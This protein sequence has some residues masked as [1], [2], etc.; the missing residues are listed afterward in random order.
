MPLRSTY[1]VLIA[2]LLNLALNA[3]SSRSKKGRSIQP[4]HSNTKLGD[5]TS[6]STGLKIGQNFQPTSPLSVNLPPGHHRSIPAIKSRPHGSKLDQTHGNAHFFYEN[7]Q[8]QNIKLTNV[9]LLKWLLVNRKEQVYLSRHFGKVRVKRS[10]ELGSSIAGIRGGIARLSK[11]SDHAETI[12]DLPKDKTVL[13]SDLAESSKDL[14]GEDNPTLERAPSSA[15]LPSLSSNDDQ[16]LAKL[17]F[18]EAIDVRYKPFLELTDDVMRKK[19]NPGFIDKEFDEDATDGTEKHQ[20]A[21]EIKERG[22]TFTAYLALYSEKRLFQ[23][24][25]DGESEV[26]T[27]RLV[28]EL[29]ELR[30]IYVTELERHLKM[31]DGVHTNRFLRDENLQELEKE[32]SSIRKSIWA[33]DTIPA[34]IEHG[35]T[36]PNQAKRVW[37]QESL[38]DAMGRQKALK[39]IDQ[40]SLADITADAYLNAGKPRSSIVL[41]APQDVTYDQV[42]ELANEAQDAMLHFKSLPTIPDN[43]AKR[44]AHRPRQKFKLYIETY[45]QAHGNDFGLFIDVQK[46]SNRREIRKRPYIQMSSLKSKLII[47]LDKIKSK[48]EKLKKLL[49][50]FKS[51]FKRKN[52]RKFSSSVSPEPF[53]SFEMV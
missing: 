35:K 44:R 43:E 33:Y 46:I 31:E 14:R 38:A 15:S 10:P 4:D 18:L 29:E 19:P 39:E 9:F 23:S 28:S 51:I 21:L 1:I 45:A 27:N 16:E 13:A 52:E 24:V 37:F 25:I 20:A 49:S 3:C 36:Q 26:E 53:A 32:V 42:I 17:G 50:R 34:T 22:L 8:G 2:I 6:V 11:G 40:R 48:I 5:D 30:S 41:E 47:W 7:P 12:S